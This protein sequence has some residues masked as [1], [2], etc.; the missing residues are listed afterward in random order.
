MRQKWK[1]EERPS[2][3]KNL[4]REVIII[5]R[6]HKDYKYIITCRFINANWITPCSSMLFETLIIFQLVKK[7]I[8]FVEPKFQ[9]GHKS[10]IRLCHESVKFIPYPHAVMGRITHSNTLLQSLSWQVDTL[11][12]SE[13]SKEPPRE[14]EHSKFQ[15]HT[16]IQSDQRI[17]ITVYVVLIWRRSC[18]N[19]SNFRFVGSLL[20][21]HPRLFTWETGLLNIVFWDVRVFCPGVW[22]STLVRNVDKHVPNLRGVTSHKRVFLIVNRLQKFRYRLIWTLIGIYRNIHWKFAQ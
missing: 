10:H 11:W 8:T 20:V 13:E 12:A 4:R 21:W 14:L 6:T 16:D 3:Y 15:C 19:P 9:C 17:Y 22:R 18:S 1:T 2:R 5:H 7:Y